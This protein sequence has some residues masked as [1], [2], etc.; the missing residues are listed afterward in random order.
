MLRLLLVAILPAASAA[1]ESGW[2]DAFRQAQWSPIIDGRFLLGQTF[3]NDRSSSWHGN[4]DIQIT[5][6]AKFSDS[7]GLIP[8]YAG[9]FEGTRSATELAGGTQLFQESQSHWLSVKG[10]YR[11]GDWKVKPQASYRWELLRETA[12]EDWGSGLFDYR[13][14]A[15]GLEAEYSAS[16]RVKANASFDY[17]AIDF[18]NYASLESRA[19]PGLGREQAGAR[20][21]NSR[22]A[23]WT[24]GGEFP[25]PV[26]NAAAR[27]SFNVTDRNFPEQHLVLASGQLA[28]ENRIDDIKSASCA[29]GYRRRLAERVAAALTLNIVEA[30]YSS[31]QNHYDPELN[32][33]NPNFYSYEERALQPGVELLIGKRKVEAS[34]SY[35]RIERSYLDRLAQDAAGTYLSDRVNLLQESFLFKL[36]VPLG[37]GLKFLAETALT[38]SSSNMAYQKVFQYNYTISNEFVGLTYSY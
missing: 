21:L 36:A 7:F 15:T 18:P 16:E 2:L 24:W 8:T 27:L 38:D 10:I 29:L 4:G 3:I 23:S 33:F 34:V 35:L 25:L 31:N 22:S 1:A 13:K 17:Y 20:T 11:A 9:S 37:R 5:P 32:V 26:E 30:R 19:L 12:D 6:A 28:G 14:P